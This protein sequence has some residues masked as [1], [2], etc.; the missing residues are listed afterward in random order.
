MFSSTAPNH[1]LENTGEMEVRWEGDRCWLL[2]EKKVKNVYRDAVRNGFELI[3]GF[4][5]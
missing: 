3:N 5:K 4:V 1:S 2:Q